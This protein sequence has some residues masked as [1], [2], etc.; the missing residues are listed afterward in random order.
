[1]RMLEHGC[2]ELLDIFFR[3]VDGAGLAKGSKPIEGRVSRPTPPRSRDTGPPGVASSGLSMSISSWPRVE[4]PDNRPC[5]SGRCL[6]FQLEAPGS[7]S[8]QATS[9]KSCRKYRSA[10]MRRPEAGDSGTR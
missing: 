10:D 3:R 6:S 2:H 4:Q 5:S 7:P 1:M 9:T 8:S